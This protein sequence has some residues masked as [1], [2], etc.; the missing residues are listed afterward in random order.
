MGNKTANIN[1][2]KVMLLNN[3]LT[4]GDML[5]GNITFLFLL[6]SVCNSVR[7]C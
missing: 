6:F 2:T 4:F 5:L 3:T 1:V 7:R